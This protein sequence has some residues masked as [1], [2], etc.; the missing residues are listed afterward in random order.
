MAKVINAKM[1]GE[2]RSRISGIKDVVVLD[3]GGLDANATCAWRRGLRKSGIQLLSGRG[4]L[5]SVVLKELGGDRLQANLQG[6]ICVAWNG[7]DI[8]TLSKAITNAIRDY[9]KI[10]IIGGIAEGSGVV[11]SQVAMFSESKGRAELLSDICAAILGPGGQIVDAV[12]AIPSG[13]V[14]AVG[15]VGGS[16]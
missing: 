13:V 9:D 1:V 5:V 15:A 6:S 10:K 3:Q 16:D 8:V 11:A 12:E 4:N 7:D 14:G 2:M